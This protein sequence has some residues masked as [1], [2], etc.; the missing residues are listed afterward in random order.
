MPHIYISVQQTPM[1]QSPT[2]KFI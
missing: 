2:S 1:G